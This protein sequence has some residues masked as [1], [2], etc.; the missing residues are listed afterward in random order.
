MQAVQKAPEGTPAA[1]GMFVVIVHSAED[2]EGKH[3]TNPYVH[4]Y[5]KGEERKTKHVKKNKDPKWNEEFSFML[6]EPPIHE[7]MHVKV[8]STSS[9]IVF[10]L[11]CASVEAAYVPFEGIKPRGAKL[12]SDG[13]AC[14][15]GFGDTTSFG[16]MAL[17]GGMA[18]MLAHHDEG[19]LTC[20]VMVRE[21]FEEIN[22]AWRA[23]RFVRKLVRQGAGSSGSWFVR[24]LVRQEAV[25]QGAGLSGS[26]FVKEPVRQGAGSSGVG[27]WPLKSQGRPSD[28]RFFLKSTFSSFKFHDH[29]K[30]IK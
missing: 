8:F 2:V 15:K 30:I 25:R 26:R 24:E 7:K 17:L 12:F 29:Y 18:I 28:L 4:I 21:S 1:G 16:D 23:C 11:R 14:S 22:M 10:V 27:V 13:S 9:R 3:H 19:V 20:H 5:F 6:E